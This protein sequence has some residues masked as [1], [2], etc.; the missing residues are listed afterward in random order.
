MVKLLPSRYLAYALS[1]VGL[2]ISLPLAIHLDSGYWVPVIFA[3]L[4][5]LGTRDMLQ[6]RHTVSRI[7][8]IVANIRYFLESF[9]PEIFKRHRRSVHMCRQIS[10]CFC[11]RWPGVFI[12][13]ASGFYSRRAV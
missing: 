9:G 3:S 12:S 11:L 7:Y 8:P 1:V 13:T 5:A 2:L 4:T 6:R 10:V